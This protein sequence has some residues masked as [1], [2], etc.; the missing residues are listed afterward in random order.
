MEAP[1]LKLR[2]IVPGLNRNH[3]MRDALVAK[4]TREA[5]SGRRLAMFDR[6]TGLYAHWYML[7]RFEEEAR[8]ADRYDCPLSVMLVEVRSDDGFRTQDEVRDWLAHEMRATDLAT[9]LGDGRFL[10]VH[11]ET[12]M[13]DAA[14]VAIRIAERFPN[15]VAV[16]LA[17]YP[18]DGATLDDLQNLAQQRA[19][20]NWALAS[21]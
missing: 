1:R 13:G 16:G 12:A 18:G 19:H 20:G 15:A 4:A 17:D 5:E 7:R 14:S 6:Q 10:T 21:V 3:G 8:R 2:R 9:H 11:T